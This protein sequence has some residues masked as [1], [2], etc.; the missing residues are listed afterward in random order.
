MF[1]INYISGCKQLLQAFELTQANL[2]YKKF[3][4]ARKEFL[5]EINQMII[6]FTQMQS[7]LNLRTFAEEKQKLLLMKQINRLI[8]FIKE[9]GMQ[10]DKLDAPD[11]VSNEEIIILFE[12][13]YKFKVIYKRHLADFV[14]LV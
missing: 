4:L 7:E 3:E 1:N 5:I 10:V 13:Q 8:K 14:A 6:L 2:L 12:R 9:F 11:Q